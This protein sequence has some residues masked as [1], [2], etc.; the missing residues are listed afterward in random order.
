MTPMFEPMQPT[1][2]M[3]NGISLAFQAYDQASM[4][5]NPITAKVR[6]KYLIVN[7]DWKEV[8]A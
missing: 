7:E 2:L 8:K 6:L 4:V 1:F 3:F 5:S